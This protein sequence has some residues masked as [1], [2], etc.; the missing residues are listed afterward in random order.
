MEPFSLAHTRWITS[1]KYYQMYR[2][3]GQQHTRQNK[4][5]RRRLLRNRQFARYAVAC[6]DAMACNIESWP[7]LDA[8]GYQYTCSRVLEYRSLDGAWIDTPC[9]YARYRNDSTWL[10]GCLFAIFTLISVLPRP[11]AVFAASSMV[12]QFVFLFLLF[13]S[14]SCH[15]C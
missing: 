11:C 10:G 4:L 15:A 13:A 5:F 12:S 7:D 9:D 6:H 3:F 2:T 14:C 8:M 1:R